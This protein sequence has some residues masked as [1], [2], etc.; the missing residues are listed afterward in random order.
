MHGERRKSGPAVDSSID[1]QSDVRKE[2]AFSR[3]QSERV[4]R[5]VRNVF[6]S[7]REAGAHLVRG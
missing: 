4:V 6:Q 2:Y 7:D 1:S 3:E 5:I